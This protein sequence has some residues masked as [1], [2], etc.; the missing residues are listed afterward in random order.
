ME[1]GSAGQDV[2]SA[3]GQGIRVIVR[4][5]CLRLIG[6]WVAALWTTS[7]V[8]ASRW[9]LVASAAGLT[10]VWPVVRLSLD[11][12][13]RMK[14][15]V[16]ALVDLLALAGLH[17][18]VIWPLA[19]T[20][21]W[22]TRQAAWIDAAVLAWSLLSAAMVALGI[23]AG[24]ALPRVIAATLCILLL[25]GEPL[26]IALFT[27]PEPGTV[28]MRISPLQTLWALSEEGRQWT[29]PPW[30]LNVIVAA[31]AALLAWG[32]VWALTALA[33]PRSDS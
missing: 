16:L 9:M 3:D 5:W 7:A 2:A 13:H 8:P 14:P 17:H 20:A 33:P 28:M 29:R 22:E 31:V 21:G 30:Q 6:T 15:A 19:L 26:F 27:A 12:P 25:F 18:A 32:V 24:Q 23:Q 11:S 4:G 10:V 1:A